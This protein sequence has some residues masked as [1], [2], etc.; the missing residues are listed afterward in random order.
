MLNLPQTNPIIYK[1][2]VKSFDL[3]QFMENDDVKNIIRL[4]IDAHRYG[5][6]VC[7]KSLEE[8]FSYSS[9]IKLL[10]NVSLNALLKTALERTSIV[11]IDRLNESLNDFYSM[12]LSSTEEIARLS[13]NYISFW[14]FV[15][16]QK[17]KDNTGIA[18]INDS[19]TTLYSIFKSGMLIGGWQAFD[20]NS[21]S[22][23]LSSQKVMDLSAR[24]NG[25]FYY[26]KSLAQIP[27]D[28]KPD[29]A[30][31]MTEDFQ[32]IYHPDHPNNR[33]I[34]TRFGESGIEIACQ[35][36]MGLTLYEISQNTREPITR[37]EALVKMLS[38]LGLVEII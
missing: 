29:F 33:K 2:Q 36:A 12:L 34:L 4:K 32:T 16:T 7:K 9:G 15:E 27:I 8:F 10:G 25:E 23:E 20:N 26:Y 38:N 17:E 22:L 21:P 1:L 6:L 3:T 18:I 5:L 14:R 28:V 19:G 37:I 30:F 31:K 13:T 11:T 35:V 24:M